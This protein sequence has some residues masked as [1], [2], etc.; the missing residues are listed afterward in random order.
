MITFDSIRCWIYYS[1]EIYVSTKNMMR[2]AE[3]RSIQVCLSRPVVLG[4][5]VDLHPGLLAH[6]FSDSSGVEHVNASGFPSLRNDLMMHPIVQSNLVSDLVS[7]STGKGG[8][9]AL[10]IGLSIVALCLRVERKLVPNSIVIEHDSVSVV[11]D[12]KGICNIQRATI[13]V[14][15]GERITIRSCTFIDQRKRKR[16]ANDGETV[17]KKI[18]HLKVLRRPAGHLFFVGF[19]SC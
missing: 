1:I 9:V 17:E 8:R 13:I 15:C 11:H 5:L 7:P 19:P 18:V 6:V 14:P 12:L 16:P 4:S 3:M 10:V 2:A